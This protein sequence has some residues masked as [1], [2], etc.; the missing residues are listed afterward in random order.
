MGCEV[1]TALVVYYPSGD[2]I[3]FHLLLSFGSLTPISL[4]DVGESHAASAHI[5]K[6]VKVMSNEVIMSVISVSCV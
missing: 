2:H 5:S 3:L 4:R 1:D 6:R